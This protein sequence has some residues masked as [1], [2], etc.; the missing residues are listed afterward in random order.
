MNS[1]FPFYDWLRIFIEM[2]VLGPDHAI[3]PL[4]YLKLL[5]VIITYKSTYDRKTKVLSN[6]TRYV[7]EITN[8][9]IGMEV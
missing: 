1:I 6:K 9:S 4:L 2:A 8:M 3:N 5:F 7:N